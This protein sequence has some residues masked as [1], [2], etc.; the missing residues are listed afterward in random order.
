MPKRY[1]IV[2]TGSYTW[3]LFDDDDNVL[4]TSPRTYETE[5]ET[6]ESIG[7]FRDVADTAEP[8]LLQPPGEAT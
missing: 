5:E 6:Q 3:V 1:L 4:A 2:K 8:E 7:A